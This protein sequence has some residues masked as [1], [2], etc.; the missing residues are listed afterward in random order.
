MTYSYNKN[1][2][3]LGNITNLKVRQPITDVRVRGVPDKAYGLYADYRFTDGALNGFGVNL[4]LDYK[5]DVAGTNATGYTTSKPISGVA[6][7]N[8]T[9]FVA[10]QPT[11]F[12]AGRTLVNVGFTY[13]YQQNW[14]AAFTVLNA[15]DKSY[16]W[17]P[18][19]APRSSSVLRAIGR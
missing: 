18:A 10:N 4:G 7:I 6:G 11:F 8:G 17:V 13:T 9:G 3:I 5:S 19:A 2:T 15:L 14:S 1:F 12:V 16:I